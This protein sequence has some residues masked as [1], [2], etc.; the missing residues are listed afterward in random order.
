MMQKIAPEHQERCVLFLC[1]HLVLIDES[2]NLV[3][4]KTAA[5]RTVAEYM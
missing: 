2:N 3:E 5:R 4:I 1:N